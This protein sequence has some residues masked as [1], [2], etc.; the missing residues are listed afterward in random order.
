MSDKYWG[1]HLTL[2]ANGCDERL[3]NN[4]DNIVNFVKTLVQRID[5][6]AFGEPIVEHFAEHDPEKAGF[7]LM[8]M[9]STSSITGHFVDATGEAY[10][11][12]F[13]CKPF[14]IQV[15]MD[16]V[17]EFFDADGMKPHYLIRDASK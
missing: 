17:T 10:I 13:S 5:M 16:T 11:D 2:D 9:I 14:D 12:V 8:Q 1:Y 4:R 3:I 6:V 7:T 15:V